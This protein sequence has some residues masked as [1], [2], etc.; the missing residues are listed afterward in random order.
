MSLVSD[1]VIHYCRSVPEGE[2]SYCKV[3]LQGAVKIVRHGSSPEWRFSGAWSMGPRYYVDDFELWDQ[4]PSGLMSCAAALVK[5]AVKAIE[6][7]NTLHRVPI[8]KRHRCQSSDSYF[9][10]CPQCE[11]EIITR[12][13]TKT[14][15]NDSPVLCEHAN[16][17]PR[18]CPCA[19]DCYCRTRT[20]KDKTDA[21]AAQP[22][23]KQ[24]AV[25]D[26]AAD[27][28]TAVSLDLYARGLG[29]LVTHVQARTAAGEAKYGTR[30][31]AFNGRDAGLD[32]L[33]EAVDL[34]KYVKQKMMEGAPAGRGWGGIYDL[35]VIIT[36]LIDKARKDTP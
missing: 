12:M 11:D 31:Q 33:Q 10:V 29:H 34:M 21:A 22:A 3:H 35:A 16:E 20:C 4:P 17:N 28:P 27:V 23:P 14:I 5:A 19:S 2:C 1:L 18:L 24:P 7:P 30:L 32:A 15:P 8:L 13:V 36:D 6:P 25:K 26:N 9:G